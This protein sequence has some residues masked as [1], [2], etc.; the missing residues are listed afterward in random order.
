MERCHSQPQPGIKYSG[1]STTSDNST[2]EAA[3]RRGDKKQCTTQTS[4]GNSVQ[5]H[6][7]EREIY[8][9]PGG[10]NSAQVQAGFQELTQSTSSYTNS[11]SSSLTDL[12]YT[13]FGGKLFMMINIDIKEYVSFCYFNVQE[14]LLL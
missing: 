12:R 10:S 8:D 11:V 6:R 7:W 2:D 4:R 13:Y 5:D 9:Y 3:G 1:M 14:C